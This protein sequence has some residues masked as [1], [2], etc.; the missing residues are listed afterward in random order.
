MFPFARVCTIN[1]HRTFS[2]KRVIDSCLG[3]FFEDIPDEA[4][5]IHGH[6]MPASRF[7]RIFNRRFGEED[8]ANRFTMSRIEQ[9]GKYLCLNKGVFEEIKFFSVTDRVLCPIYV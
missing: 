4:Q 7:F 2:K 3:V 8:L 5:S 9:Y 6:S 1:L